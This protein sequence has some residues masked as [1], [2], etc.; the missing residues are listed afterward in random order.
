MNGFEPQHMK[1]QDQ[2]RILEGLL[3]E[4]ENKYGHPR[5]VETHDTIP[6]LTRY[7]YKHSRGVSS[8][9]GQR[10]TGTLEAEAKPGQKLMK[11]L[12]AGGNQE[13][14]AKIKVEN[15][16]YVELMARCNVLEEIHIITSIET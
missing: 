9:T 10:K 11:Q 12:G 4:S 13:G 15:P 14:G 3:A 1:K 5:T 2:E 6:E 16:K 8:S 7:Y